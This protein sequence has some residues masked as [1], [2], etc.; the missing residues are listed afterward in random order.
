LLFSIERGIVRSEIPDQPG[1]AL[2]TFKG[3]S[4]PALP[5]LKKDPAVIRALLYNLAIGL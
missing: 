1:L 4:G 5:V 3:P 2:N